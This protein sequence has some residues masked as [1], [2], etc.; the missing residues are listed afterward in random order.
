GPAGN[1]WAAASGDKTVY[2]DASGTVGVIDADGVHTLENP[3]PVPEEPWFDGVVTGD[4]AFVVGASGRIA[5]IDV[6][7]KTMVEVA[8]PTVE[9]WTAI[10]THPTGLVFGGIGGRLRVADASGRLTQ[11]LYLGVPDPVREQGSSR[12]PRNSRAADITG[13][14]LAPGVADHQWIQTDLGL[15]VSRDGGSSACGRF[16]IE[17]RRP[18][19]A[20]HVGLLDASRGFVTSGFG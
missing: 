1:T 7:A 18:A 9:R 13:L 14:W 20:G 4:T 5:R 10:E 3:W 15:F 2:A 6:G 11:R 8:S 12:T 16:D 17:G 19:G